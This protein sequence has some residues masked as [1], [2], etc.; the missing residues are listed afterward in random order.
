MCRSVHHYCLNH[1]YI[2][3]NDLAD[4]LVIQI[5][6]YFVLISRLN[7]R[8]FPFP[9]NMVSEYLFFLINQLNPGSDNVQERSPLL[10]EP[11]LYLIK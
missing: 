1:D 7:S 2:R 9:I 11:R 3:L 5:C 10:S 6:L 8:F 4:S